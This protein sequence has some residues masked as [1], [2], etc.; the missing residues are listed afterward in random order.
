MLHGVGLCGHKF[1]GWGDKCWLKGH[2][3]EAVAS[4]LPVL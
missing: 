3:A 2:K 4:G 1:F